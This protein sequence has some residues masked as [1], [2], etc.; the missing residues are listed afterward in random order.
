MRRSSNRVGVDTCEQNDGLQVAKAAE[1]LVQAATKSTAESVDAARAQLQKELLRKKKAERRAH[2]KQRAKKSVPS[3][4]ATQTRPESSTKVASVLKQTAQSQ[5][6]VVEDTLEN[7]CFDPLLQS[8]GGH[9]SEIVCAVE[10]TPEANQSTEQPN[11]RCQTPTQASSFAIDTHDS[12]VLEST[13]PEAHEGAPLVMACHKRDKASRQQ[14]TDK[15][16]RKL[17]ANAAASRIQKA[18]KKK[19]RKRYHSFLRSSSK[20]FA[21]ECHPMTSAGLPSTDKPSGCDTG[22]AGEFESSTTVTIESATDLELPYG[23]SNSAQQANAPPS[24]PQLSEESGFSGSLPPVVLEVLVDKGTTKR[25]CESPRADSEC[26]MPSGSDSYDKS[27]SSSPSSS[28]SRSCSC[29]SSSG[30]SDDSIE[31]RPRSKGSRSP[32]GPPLDLIQDVRSRHQ[33]PSM[34]LEHAAVRLQAWVRGNQGRQL[35]LELEQELNEEMRLEALDEIRSEASVHIQAII[36]GYLVRRQQN[37][38]QKRKTSGKRTKAV[39]PG[40]TL[41]DGDE[42]SEY[43]AE[44]PSELNLEPA[45]GWDQLS[46]VSTSNGDLL[47]HTEFLSKGRMRVFCGTWNLH[48]KRPRD[49]LRLWIGL[50]KYHIVAVGSEECVNSIAKSVVFTSKKQWE[51]LLKDTLGDEYVMV[52]SHSL[53]AIH[54]VVFAH[55]SVVPLLRHVQSDAVATGIGNQLGNKGGVGIAFTMGKTSFAF[56]NCHFDAHQHNVEKRNANFHR[57]NKELRLS[58]EASATTVDTGEHPVIN[59]DRMLLTAA[60]SSSS[61]R[62]SIN[63]SSRRI[64]ETFDRVFW[65][66]DLNYRINGTRRMVDHLLLKNELEVL[67]FNDQLLIEMKRGQVFRHF[68]EGPLNFRPTYKFDKNCNVY[69]TSVKQRIPSWTD[70]ILYLSNQKAQDIE[71]LRYASEA[72][73]Q[74]SDHRPVSAVFDVRFNAGREAVQR[75][76]SR[77]L[78]H[79]YKPTAPKSEACVV[80]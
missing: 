33:D 20:V 9:K 39:E 59:R 29:C 54:N 48:A 10:P 44:W 35:A 2:A 45:Q 18:L 60:A 77:V 42:E 70:R 31:N 58:P 32:A 36:R 8:S 27:Q 30:E 1:D 16:S 73:F 75:G 5:A 63:H 12:T 19:L 49:D 47:T 37:Q 38:R 7:N 55:N 22:D 66:G 23:L 57:I 15:S 61:K 71:L 11:R 64:S 72:S 62:R 6:K 80:Q 65:F 28:K 21:E 3:E 17:N 79:G 68:Q 26:T 53:T 51:E 74:T 41:N 69:D 40:G 43:A 14:A 50:N 34:T 46:T 13:V 76:F 4:D 25:K 52:A 78:A 67:H 56:V 24:N